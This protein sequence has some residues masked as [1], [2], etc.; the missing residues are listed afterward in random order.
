MGVA[1]LKRGR[2]FLVSY[3]PAT[4]LAQEE[5]AK[6]KMLSVVRIQQKENSVLCTVTSR[7]NVSIKYAY[8]SAEK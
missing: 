3:G 4:S 5:A 8:C 6:T 7:L 2:G 1:K